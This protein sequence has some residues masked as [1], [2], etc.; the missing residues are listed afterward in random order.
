MSGI[1]MGCASVVEVRLK[2]VVTVAGCEVVLGSWSWG[3]E[4]S[5]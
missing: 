5:S 2:F 3:F 1:E 4:R